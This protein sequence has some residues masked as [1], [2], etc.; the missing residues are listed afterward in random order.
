MTL[1]V[2]GMT[3]GH[4]KM[5]VKEALESVDGSENV[6]VDLEAGLATVD[7]NVDPQLLIAAVAEEGYKAS[8]NG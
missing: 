6:S 8:L 2:E 3:C 1:K 5:A 4:C 7:G